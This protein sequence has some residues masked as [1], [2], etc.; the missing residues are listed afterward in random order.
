MCF[1]LLSYTNVSVFLFT[2]VFWAAVS[3]E[4]FRV[5]I[6]RCFFGCCLIPMF[7][8]FGLLSYTDVFVFLFTDVFLAAV[9]YQS[10]FL[11]TDV[12]WAVVSYQCFR[13]SI[14]RCVLGFC[15]IPM[16]MER[17]TDVKHKCPNCKLKLGKYERYEYVF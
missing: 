10:V 8:C 14:Y 4:C 5:S 9:S 1:G 12:F 16:F 7:S 3:Y 11:Y 6:Y 15:L 2:D 17:F 13:V